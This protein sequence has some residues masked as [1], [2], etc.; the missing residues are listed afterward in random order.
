LCFVDRL[1]ARNAASREAMFKAVGVCV[2]AAT[3]ATAFEVK[4][5]FV[6]RFMLEV[7]DV[8]MDT[9]SRSRRLQ[10]IDWDDTMRNA[11][12]G[13]QISSLFHAAMD[14]TLSSSGRRLTYKPKT[15]AAENMAKWMDITMTKN[16]NGVDMAGEGQQLAENN[17]CNEAIESI[18][19]SLSSVHEGAHA[20]REAIVEVHKLPQGNS[21]VQKMKKFLQGWVANTL[22]G[23][24]G[25]LKTSFHGLENILKG[26]A[27]AAVHTVTAAIGQLKRMGSK[28][29]HFFGFYDVR[30]IEAAISAPNAVAVLPAPSSV[31]LNLKAFSVV[32]FPMVMVAGMMTMLALLVAGI[33][34]WTKRNTSVDSME[35]DTMLAVDVE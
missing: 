8:Q 2:A 31:T 5:E 14:G 11:T 28:V 12:P 34:Q 25:L 35:T 17:A 13:E 33:R 9:E 7:L 20:N 23:N 4:S 15:K 32:K 22:S 3:C 27:H 30:A 10:G 19:S 18:K 16:D 21:V 26:V 1:L 6:A 29:S 24:I